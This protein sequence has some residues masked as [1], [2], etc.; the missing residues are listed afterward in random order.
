MSPPLKQHESGTIPNPFYEKLR[1]IRPTFGGHFKEEWAMLV[2]EA[3]WIETFRLK[4]LGEL[5]AAMFK[6]RQ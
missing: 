5:F 4:N 2:N 1:I 6:K 3:I